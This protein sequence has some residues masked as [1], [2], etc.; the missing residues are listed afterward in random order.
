MTPHVPRPA[1]RRLFPPR[2]WRTRNGASL[3]VWSVIAVLALAAMLVTTALL[4]DLLVH[5]GR[6]SVPATSVAALHEM[7]A[8]TRLTPVDEPTSGLQAYENTGLLPTVWAY[9]EHWWCAPVTWAWRSCTPLQSNFSALLC[10][11]GAT[12]VAGAVRISAASHVR[13]VASRMATEVAIGLR[14]SIHRQA[15]RLGPSDLDGAEQRTA[16]DLFVAATSEA[17][18]GLTEWLSHVVRAPLTLGLLMALL[19]IVD[20]RLGLQCLIP[21][22]VVGWVIQEERTRGAAMR[23]RSEAEAQAEL[24][25]L[26]EGLRKTRLVRAYGMEEFEHEQFQKHLAR[27]SA[28]GQRGRVGETWALRTARLLTLVL[29]TIIAFL[30]ASR[31]LS[32][33]APLSL[34]GVWLFAAALVGLSGSLAS[35][36]GLWTAQQ[37]AAIPADRIY[38]YLSE[39]PEVS[40]AVGAK[41]LNPLSQSL[42]LEAVT[43]QRDGKMLLD[44]IDLRIPARTKT[45]LI[46]NDP[47]PPRAIAYLLPRFIEPQSGRIL[48]DSEDIAWS[49][50][51]SLRAETI[52]VAAEDPFF[53]GTVLENLTCGESRFTLQ[54]AIEAC[55]LT[56]AH[57]F[58]TAL[59]NGYET[60][61]GEHGEQLRPGEAFRLGLARAALR[62]PAVLIIEEPQGRLDE[63]SKALIDDAYQRL[64]P[65]RTVIF[66]PTRL[67][68]VRMCDQVVYLQNGQIEAIGNQTELVKTC[69]GYRHWEYVNFA[70]AGKV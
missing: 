33:R 10:L 42:I 36:R 17:R 9:H 47:L 53:T 44:R 69:E 56:H 52:Y 55:K 18:Q 41:F 51:E 25:P 3:I 62:N 22:G 31:A 20:W 29:I 45:A 11:L 59:P 24:R 1:F 46:S 50:L 70:P 65:G 7:L 40:Q 61:L 35:F 64:L 60:L 28:E 63:D 23:Q 49:T 54:E 57:K 26:A 39:I 43:Y 27:Y 16:V 15:M 34:G 30:L 21:L 19:L 67:A 14:R 48:F 37:N 38:R 2:L 66:L 4:L 32:D 13:V 12:L 5:R 68:T 6:L 8:E 58:I